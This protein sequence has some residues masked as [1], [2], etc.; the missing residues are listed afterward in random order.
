[1][2]NN[3]LI[4]YILFYA[5]LSNKKE[6]MLFLLSAFLLAIK[7]TSKCNSRCSES[8]YDAGKLMKIGVSWYEG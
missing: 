4:F 3:Y 7:Y 5:I 8:K 1:M 6:Y 2:C